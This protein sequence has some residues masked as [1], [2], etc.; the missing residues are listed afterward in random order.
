MSGRAAP[1]LL[2]ALAGCTCDVRPAE[3]PS[4][5]VP[6]EWRSE[7]G[8]DTPIDAAW[9]RSFGDPQ[10]TALVE[11]ALANNS[12]LGI[13][14][15]QI[16]EAR[17]NL[18]AVSAQL[19]PELDAGMTGGRSRS[20]SAFG[21]PLVQNFAQPQI[22]ASY[23]IDLFG[24]LG[25]REGAAH[26][27]VL[28]EEA[29]HAAA[30][31]STAS[32]TVAA[33]ITLLGLD[34]RLDVARR[35]LSARADSLRVA[36]SRAGLGYAPRLE[37]DQAEAE[38]QAALQII[39]Q[40]QIA[41][42]KVEDELSQL[43][44]ETPHAIARGVKLD[45]LMNADVAPGLPS[46]LLRRRPDIAQAERRLAATDRLLSAARKRFLPRLAFSASDGAAI[47]SLFDPISIWSM[48]GS[49][50]A[51]IFDG[52]RIAGAA[53][54]AAGQRDQA[55]YAY[56]RVVLSAFRETED[57]LAAIR[58][59]DQRVTAAA[60]Q[61]DALQS[62]LQRATRRYREGYSPYIEQLDAERQLLVA[63]LDYVQA[64]TEAFNARVQLFAALGGGWSP[65]G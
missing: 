53:E 4:V 38:Y 51:P 8:S 6:A 17:G 7:M 22:L 47:S 45:E 48:G 43:T 44:G 32:T 64:R 58:R 5:P 63:Q 34:A 2:L 42:A 41:I 23:E 20:V 10:L 52:G 15:G 39:P 11:R 60:A 1:L 54:A 29:A 56:R 31:L 36:R 13:S 19:L 16:R 50:L 65:A 9:W 26:D 25:D 46:E 24:R 27:I 28:A 12:D 3:V 61:R 35:T 62:A 14:A 40:A 57:A 18:T 30:R 55:A 37:L 49:V 33:Y 59:S 21:K